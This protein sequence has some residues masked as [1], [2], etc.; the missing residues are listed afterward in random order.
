MFHHT[1]FQN[2]WDDNQLVRQIVNAWLF[3]I[4]SRSLAFC[5]ISF[6]VWISPVKIQNSAARLRT[7]FD[8]LIVF[9]SVIFRC[10]QFVATSIIVIISQHSSLSCCS[11]NCHHHHVTTSFINIMWLHPSQSSSWRYIHHHGAILR[12][13]E[14][15]DLGKCF[16]MQRIYYEAMYESSFATI[17]MLKTLCRVV[18]K[19]SLI[20]SG[21]SYCQLYCT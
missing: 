19:V 2:G 18:L 5:G 15:P 7:S 21:F 10:Y 4:L 13:L 6:A 12:C 17:G 20:N 16:N 14:C 1:L 3:T 9:V 11:I 8:S